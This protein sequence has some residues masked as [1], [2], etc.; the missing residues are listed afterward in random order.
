MP[1]IDLTKYTEPYRF[2]T[3]LPPIYRPQSGSARR[4]GAAVDRF[5]GGGE[6][7]EG[8]ETPRL[9][10]EQFRERERREE[11]KR[12]LAAAKKGRGRRTTVKEKQPFPQPGK[13]IR[14]ADDM[15]EL[16]GYEKPEDPSEP[17][18]DDIEQLA[19]EKFGDMGPGESIAAAE[20][21]LRQQYQERKRKLADWKRRRRYVAGIMYEEQRRLDPEH[22]RQ[23]M[24]GSRRPPTPGREGG[25]RDEAAPREQRAPA[26]GTSEQSKGAPPTTAAAPWPARAAPA[27]EKGVKEEAV[28]PLT[29]D[30]GN[31][32][33]WLEEALGIEPQA[34]YT[35]EEIQR[36]WG[37][38]KAM[39]QRR[40]AGDPPPNPFDDRDPAAP[41]EV[42]L[43][44]TAEQVE[45]LERLREAGNERALAAWASQA[46]SQID[47]AEEHL[48][49]LRK[50]GEEVAQTRT[51]GALPLDRQAET[52]RDAEVR[53]LRKLYDETGVLDA[54]EKRRLEA[55]MR[56]SREGIMSD[57]SPRPV[58]VQAPPGLEEDAGAVSVDAV[59]AAIQE[60]MPD[61]TP[62]ER[63]EYRNRVADIVDLR[64]KRLQATTDRR[65]AN[66]AVWDQGFE[67]PTDEQAEMMRSAFASPIDKFWF[68]QALRNAHK[69]QYAELHALLQD[70]FP[71]FLQGD[72]DQTE[73]E[74]E[75]KVI[76]AGAI[77]MTGRAE[78]IK[79]SGLLVAQGDFLTAA[80]QESD[81]ALDELTGQIARAYVEGIP[82]AGWTATN[83]LYG[84]G[85]MALDLASAVTLGD[86][87]E[88]VQ[89]AKAWW[90]DYT[91]G[92][93]NYWSEDLPQQLVGVAS[94]G[95]GEDIDP[96]ELKATVLHDMRRQYGDWG[97]EF[98][99]LVGSV[100][101]I[102]A[103][104]GVAAPM[105]IA[106]FANTTI[107]LATNTLPYI[108]GG[109]QEMGSSY[110]DLRRR[111]YNPADALKVSSARGAVVAATTYAFGKLGRLAGGSG[112]PED[113]A[114]MV[115]QATKEH[116]A[117][118]SVPK[119]A[120]QFT[121]TG[122]FEGLEETSQELAGAYI[123]SGLLD[124]EL[125]L[126]AN[127]LARVFIMS[128]ILGVLTDYAAEMSKGQ[129]AAQARELAE[130]ERATQAIYEELL[131]T[132]E[133]LGGQFEALLT[134]QIL[135]PDAQAQ[136]DAMLAPE[137]QDDI[138]N[139]ANEILAV[140]DE[141]GIGE[142]LTDEQVRE[143][144]GEEEGLSTEQIEQLRQKMVDEGVLTDEQTA[145]LADIARPESLTMEQIEQLRQK[146]VDEGALTVEQTAALA[147]IA[148]PES[149]TMEQ[150]D[151]LGKALGDAGLD[152]RFVESL[153]ESFHVISDSVAA[154]K[155]KIVSSRYVIQ[156]KRITTLEHLNTGK[157]RKK[158][159]K[160]AAE[161]AAER[162]APK[163]KRP[164][165]K[166]IKTA[167]ELAYKRADKIRAEM[168]KEEAAKAK[169]EAKAERKAKREEAKAE[170]EAK[171]KAKPKKSQETQSAEEI[172]ETGEVSVQQG[173]P[174]GQIAEG[175]DG[176][177]D[178][179]RRA[180]GEGRKVSTR[181]EAKAQQIA[182]ALVERRAARVLA[183]QQQA[184]RTPEG[185][186]ERTLEA[187]RTEAKQLS[188]EERTRRRKNLATK[189]T[190]AMPEG[191]AKGVSV[192]ADP[193]TSGVL[194]KGT[195]GTEV[196]VREATQADVDRAALAM[197]D[198]G[199]KNENPVGF[200]DRTNNEVVLF[201]E[202]EGD[203]TL[204]HELV[205]W[206]ERSGLIREDEWQQLVQSARNA[207]TVDG[208]TLSQILPKGQRTDSELVAHYIEMAK[209]GQIVRPKQGIIDR[210]RNFFR[211]LLSMVRLGPV[212]EPTAFRRV[213]SGEVAAR[214]PA[215]T[216]ADRAAAKNIVDAMPEQKDIVTEAEAQEETTL[217]GAEPLAQ[218][219]QFQRVLA[220]I[221]PVAPGEQNRVSS[222]IKRYAKDPT[223][224][225]RILGK[226][227]RSAKE[228]IP[229]FATIRNPKAE[230]FAWAVTNAKGKTIAS[231]VYSIG[232]MVGTDTPIK[233]NDFWARMVAL[234]SRGGATNIYWAHNHPSSNVT[235]SRADYNMA[236]QLGLLAEKIGFQ[237]SSFLILDTDTF[238][239][240]DRA[241]VAHQQALAEPLPS[242]RDG[243]VQ[244]LPSITKP[245][246]A[247][248][249][250]KS[251]ATPE[252]MPVLAHIDAHARVVGVEV[253]TE[254]PTAEH[255]RASRDAVLG[256][257]SLLLADKQTAIA[258]SGKDGYLADVIYPDTIYPNVGY[259]QEELASGTRAG[260]Y[261]STIPDPQDTIVDQATIT[262]TIDF[263][264]SRELAGAIK[265]SEDVSDT[266]Q[267]IT[268]DILAA[269]EFDGRLAGALLR[270]AKGTGPARASAWDIDRALDADP[271]LRRDVQAFQDR[272]NKER[273]WGINILDKDGRFAKSPIELR[274]YEGSLAG[275]RGAEPTDATRPQFGSFI[276]T[277]TQ[278]YLETIPS[279][280]F[281]RWRQDARDLILGELRRQKR[282]RPGFAKRRSLRGLAKSDLPLFAP[283]KP[284]M[285]TLAAF[286]LSN[287]CPMFQIGAH[288][289][290]LD[291][292][293]LSLMGA[294]PNGINFYSKSAYFAEVLLLTNAEV[295][296][297]NKVGGVRV[298]GQGDSTY[299]LDIK[300]QW[301][302]FL[303][304]CKTRGLEVKIITKQEGTFQILSEL[305]EEGMDLSGVMV[306]PTVDPYFCAITED[307]MPKSGMREMTG[308]A[309]MTYEQAKA[310]YGELFGREVI[311]VGGVLYRK[312][313][314]SVDQLRD[315]EG[316]YPNLSQLEI[317]PRIVVATPL[318]I[319]EAALHFPEAIQ[320]W[321]HAKLRPGLYSSVEGKVLGEGDTLN[322]AN[323]NAVR[324]VDGEWFIFVGGMGSQTSGPNTVLELARAAEQQASLAGDKLT[325]AQMQRKILG[326][327]KN[328]KKAASALRA[329]AKA[330]T[331]AARLTALAT[332]LGDMGFRS[333][334]EQN[335]QQQIQA[336]Q[337]KR[338][339]DQNKLK[340]LKALKKLNRDGANLDTA[341]AFATVEDFIKRTYPPQQ[342]NQIFETLAGQQSKDAGALCCS[343]G[344][345]L[346]EC[347]NCTSAC[348]DHKGIE[349]SMADVSAEANKWL[350]RDQES[351]NVLTDS[352]LSR[353]SKMTA[354]ERTEP[355]E[356]MRYA[357]N[358]LR[359]RVLHMGAGPMTNADRTV[360]ANAA[361]VDA[362]INYDPNWDD[363]HAAKIGNADFDT[364]VA[365][366]VA[367]VLPPRM[368]DQ[369]YAQVADSLA[370]GG[371][372]VISVP[373]AAAVSSM[374]DQA[375]WVPY[376]DGYIV[377][378]DTT[379][380]TFLRG[381]TKRDLTAELGRFFDSV[382]V[383][384]QGGMFVAEASN[385]KDTLDMS[386]DRRTLANP[387][388]PAPV[389]SLVD[390]IKE[391]RQEHHLSKALDPE[392]FA[393]WDAAATEALEKMGTA[394]AARKIVG[395]GELGPE[396][397][398]MAMKVID[399]LG[400]TAARTGTVE[401]VMRV[402]KVVS[403][404]EDHRTELAR[405]MA[406]GRDRV[407]APEERRRALLQAIYSIPDTLDFEL[408]RL[409]EEV[410]E[411]RRTSNVKVLRKLEK[412][413]DRTEARITAIVQK[414]HQRLAARGLSMEDFA[415]GE[416]LMDERAFAHAMREVAHT[417]APFRSMWGA[418]L[419]EWW[420]NSILSGPITQMRNIV[421]NATMLGLTFGVRH[422]V[423]ATI[424]MMPGVHSESGMTFSELYH[425]WGGI[426][427]NVPQACVNAI[428][429]F[430]AEQDVWGAQF[431]DERSLLRQMAK[432]GVP[433]RT[434]TKLEGPRAQ[435]PG[436][437]GRAI[438]TPGR[439]L[440]AMDSF[441]K[442][443]VGN[444][445]AV[446]AANR[447]A[448]QRGLTG[449]DRDRFIDT[450][451][452]DPSS[453]AWLEAIDMAREATFQQEGPLALRSIQQLR[454]WQPDYLG[455]MQPFSFVLPFTRTPWNIFA[456]TLH[457]S[458]IGPVG[459]AIK[460]ATDIARRLQGQPTKRGK[461]QY[462][463]RVADHIVTGMLSTLVYVLNQG[464][465][466]DDR[467]V[468][469]GTLAP[470]R[471]NKPLRSLQ[472]RTL[473]ANSVRF[474]SGDKA[475]YLDYAQIEPFGGAIPLTV[476]FIQDWQT[477]GP[478]ESIYR[479][480]V[481]NLA[482]QVRDKTFL[483]GIGDFLS[484]YENLEEQ[485]SVA[486]F[487]T[488]LPVR[489]AS[490]VII[491]F[492]PNALRQTLR[493][494]QEGLPEYKPRP[495]E[496]GEGYLSRQLRHIG[497]QMWPSE[498]NSAPTKI[499]LWGEEVY[500]AGAPDT[501]FLYRMLTGML[502]P[503]QI[504]QVR[505]DAP[506]A[507][508]DTLIVRYN[509]LHPNDPARI[510]GPRD[511]FTYRGE[512]VHMTEDEFHA[513]ATAKGEFARAVLKRTRLNYRNPTETDIEKIKE[514]LSKGHKWAKG[515][516]FG[517][518]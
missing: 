41:S 448:R 374:P 45:Q 500:R 258:L 125:E 227:I 467:P 88:S 141:M 261:Q 303:A 43:N 304:D 457:L 62:E 451:M 209:E 2:D 173:E 300:N 414:T 9:S 349:A 61:M 352:A 137:N 353:S 178:Q 136:V 487:A 146:M 262:K 180:Q 124:E 105:K 426:I 122:V 431:V 478:S 361:D 93:Q 481:P 359:G 151:D 201:P 76:P 315:I 354:E 72:V 234:H 194:I 17:S 338:N 396:T 271:S 434:G 497:R 421:G 270:K 376:R 47:K 163:K 435:I 231:G 343:A 111:G 70:N 1:N 403:A 32:D 430:D 437:M 83:W 498:S 233:D 77:A 279:A 317:R 94:M 238:S 476:D 475:T 365:P 383:K 447:Y 459:T 516:V 197:G 395:Q 229:L 428:R 218:D 275:E 379:Q 168:A 345:N 5:I 335:T 115:E 418:M 371:A 387:A 109:M 445:T 424:N 108:V 99:S 469:T 19:Q 188:V 295:K 174:A 320:T 285:K 98:M 495:T 329:A 51:T 30:N 411:A 106:G 158:Q 140:A 58:D 491:G 332:E 85:D 49:D 427:R 133:S 215:V 380:A 167:L 59:F 183:E 67:F 110:Y 135:P 269:A 297:L 3:G 148:R 103:T 386:I 471:K 325:H 449:M 228:A 186:A 336:E 328:Q 53:R 440:N 119:L 145:A 202:V 306:Q 247:A 313:A 230:V 57:R 20:K 322:F 190:R 131:R 55:R 368:R 372:A 14:E 356:A 405:A 513:Y 477:S 193:D 220:G 479:M 157:I 507:A 29:T 294:G 265:T 425:I 138:T 465:D 508:L 127:A 68:D 327:A 402:A 340:R 485:D 280:Q 102:M 266:S 284:A 351:R 46:W 330:K 308:G 244:N 144:A 216:A 10:E 350:D 473:P 44:L 288:G 191:V 39:V 346:G 82:Q 286:N 409:M 149:L 213:A 89:D 69:G 496:E 212:S 360:L 50:W 128:T 309:D 464:D 205:H 326:S 96:R 242:F 305:I 154:P 408:K 245:E 401:D 71:E 432:G 503:A 243:A 312:Y 429:S 232:D 268:D 291:A 413:L 116:I 26:E 198:L 162:H 104:G 298:N 436:I 302:D 492:S 36:A 219:T 251:L 423:W 225:F 373:S 24:T 121:A 400:A 292:C 515:K 287:M 296:A 415:V 333:L 505:K 63:E 248:P 277:I 11:H 470:G 236:D 150:I 182:Q 407:K 170:R 341:A 278:A 348:H 60:A 187:A 208:Q 455:G 254:T 460:T 75:A 378:R 454:N 385:V 480:L 357:A 264:F 38:H 342:A 389:R 118:G 404:Y 33:A 54:Y 514:A 490:N 235:A 412:R 310:F 283:L 74:V 463:R 165:K 90:R 458:P 189:I 344:A 392:S 73:R 318:E 175:E 443:M 65:R 34:V 393:E 422:P 117:R 204:D 28:D 237:G 489:F 129:S 375:A 358:K 169:E 452:N 40:S 206:Y 207:R 367:H 381:Y 301:R 246:A 171:R 37:E 494:T 196:R 27:G 79:Q 152:P 273:G 410:E 512:T 276:R 282:N 260:L 511:W 370:E 307:D 331:E 501:T 289:C 64:S 504:R 293:Y 81:S 240:I 290:Y 226:K 384:K 482:A 377:G 210:I 509:E 101:P 172:S 139:M 510:Q 502:S 506:G 160:T 195:E 252:G 92:V 274:A 143:L 192:I 493:A 249:M 80:A 323:S 299:D 153:V 181:Q 364:V 217:A 316:K 416:K 499:N 142:Q 177:R 120:W 339:P 438:R 472:Y 239:T 78:E 223:T 474:G 253:L 97:V 222:L 337:A 417:Q 42:L 86:A 450:M 6:E 466:D 442:T 179:V 184:P 185:K 444:A 161:L 7:R 420:I 130:I 15:L 355:S 4:L 461:D 224:S 156:G 35:E 132:R 394:N 267:Q 87:N 22:I 281:E 321:M 250:F 419:Q 314:F 456:I 433:Q 52:P 241:G 462:V 319:A 390:D 84:L 347:M 31:R 164:R 159:L 259:P 366:S 18:S 483:R 221:E 256:H 199:I 211:D 311:D 25:E 518:R 391:Y 176:Q 48:R 446:G 21:E 56:Q 107:R 272:I 214:A 66:A 8:D 441:F 382:S 398:R 484:A 334:S 517:I 23:I 16:Y 147:D 95:I 439:A 200:Y 257:M 486:D 453:P 155:R 134:R 388:G 406:A 397:T 114:R 369:F 166:K 126:E 468:F 112:G 362:V 100:A 203:F 399:R 12:R 363:Q 255:I 91:A 113:I 123:E 13:A 263:A 488:S 324:K